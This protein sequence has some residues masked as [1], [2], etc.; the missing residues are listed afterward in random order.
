[1]LHPHEQNPG[2]SLF[3]PSHDPH[4]HI[5]NTEIWIPLHKYVSDLGPVHMGPNAQAP[6]PLT[7][8]SKFQCGGNVPAFEPQ[9]T[10]KT[11]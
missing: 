5:F 2:I 3:H 10:I 7:N 11:W 8:V 9:H 1:M 6:P 4:H